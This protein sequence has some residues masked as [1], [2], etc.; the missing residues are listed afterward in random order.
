[1]GAGAKLTVGPTGPPTTVPVVLTCAQHHTSAVQWDVQK[2][3]GRRH[4]WLIYQKP[5][6]QSGYIAPALL[7]FKCLKH[8]R[9]LQKT[10]IIPSGGAF[11]LM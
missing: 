9:L 4:K 1:M 2:Y 7:A 5:W 8:Q 3:T 6:Q 11:M 10:M